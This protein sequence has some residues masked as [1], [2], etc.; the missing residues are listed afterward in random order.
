MAAAIESEFG[1]QTELIQDSGGKFEVV[2]D[3]QLV[4]SKLKENRFPE[5]QEIIAKLA[6]M[7]TRH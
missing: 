3:G 2:A 5:P 1:I 4:F 7:S 6:E